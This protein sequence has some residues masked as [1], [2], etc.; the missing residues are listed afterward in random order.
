M[1]EGWRTVGDAP[2]AGAMKLFEN[3]S[4]GGGVVA[5]RRQGMLAKPEGDTSR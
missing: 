1:G 3:G 4:S 5:C 2:L